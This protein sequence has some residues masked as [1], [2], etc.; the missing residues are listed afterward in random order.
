MAKANFTPCT[1]GGNLVFVS[2]QRGA[3]NGK[4][5]PGGAPAELSQ[6][7][8]NVAQ[9]LA[10]ENLALK[11]IVKV[12]LFIVDIGNELEHIDEEYLR[13]LSDPLPARTV[14]GV[15]ALTGN[16]AVA[17]DVIAKRALS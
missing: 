11:D 16:A 8:R 5:V 10:A 15:S 9:M 1:A 14:V 2:G 7:F 13:I 12:T 3:A 17:V 6:A 4:V